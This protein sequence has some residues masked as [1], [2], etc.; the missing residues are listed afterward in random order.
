MTGWWQAVLVDETWTYNAEDEA[1]IR[2][3]L[4]VADFAEILLQARRYRAFAENQK[5]RPK[6]STVRAQLRK[7]AKEGGT[8]AGLLHNVDQRVYEAI[9]KT[10][11]TS[12]DLTAL[13]K[14]ARRLELL[15]T[16][17]A[18]TLKV[19]TKPGDDALWAYVNAL[20]RIWREYVR[21]V[22]TTCYT[23]R[24]N[25]GL[26]GN[27]PAFAHAC[28]ESVLSRSKQVSAENV[29]RKICAAYRDSEELAPKTG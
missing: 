1:A 22:D 10:G 13:E 17:A 27:L 19:E 29:L 8:L 21:D 6:P 23:D 15:A 25:G 7:L 12:L 28:F 2:E 5:A 24:T 14:S 20:V 4:P 18:D 9:V 3:A 26:T 16:R 11:G